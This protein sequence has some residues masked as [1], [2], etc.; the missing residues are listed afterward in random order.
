MDWQVRRKEDRY[1]EER[2]RAGKQVDKWVAR[3]AGRETR[4]VYV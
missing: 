2:R 4:Y 3:Q 1:L